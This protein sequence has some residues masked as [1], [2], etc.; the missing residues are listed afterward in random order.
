MN[1][2]GATVAV[3]DT[4]DAAGR[5]LEALRK[6]G[7]DP[8]KISITGLNDRGGRDATLGRGRKLFGKVGAAGQILIGMLLGGLVI[9]ILMLGRIIFPG[10]GGGSNAGD[11]EGLAL[12]V[13]VGALVGAFIALGTR[14]D[15]GTRYDA[16]I[17]ADM[18]R[19]TVEGSRDDIALARSALEPTPSPSPETRREQPPAAK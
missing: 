17:R 12:A 4:R 10:L 14:R 16:P 5:G 13:V 3:Y 15:S 9:F 7:L 8:R 6:A 19:L 1:S 11:L 18:F 2:S